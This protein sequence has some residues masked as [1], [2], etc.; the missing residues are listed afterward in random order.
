MTATFK[1]FAKLHFIVFLWGFTA[2]IGKEL[3]ISA[4]DVVMY[5]TGLAAIVL[6]VFMYPAKRP[7]EIPSES[8][9]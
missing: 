8:T 1:D 9:S 4:A 6:G 5:R 7:S 2:I 3:S